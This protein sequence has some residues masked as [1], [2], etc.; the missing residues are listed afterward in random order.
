MTF[1][2][3]IPTGVNASTLFCRAGLVISYTAFSGVTSLSC[4]TQGTASPLLSVRE[5]SVAWL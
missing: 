5:A 4:I 3:I 2:Q 1:C